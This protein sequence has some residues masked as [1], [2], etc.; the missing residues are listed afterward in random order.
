MLVRSGHMEALQ[1]QPC[2]QIACFRAQRMLVDQL[3]IHKVGSCR[4]WSAAAC[5]IRGCCSLDE[6]CVSPSTHQARVAAASARH[7]WLQLQPCLDHI[8]RPEQAAVRLKPYAT[9]QLVIWAEGC[10]RVSQC[11]KGAS[12]AAKVPP[13]PTC[14][15]YVISLQVL[16]YR[17]CDCCPA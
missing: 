16:T 13:C 10:G 14:R 9:E 8:C 11:E 2:R 1:C 12:C 15:A 4:E 7:C 3:G 6:C 5:M 17:V